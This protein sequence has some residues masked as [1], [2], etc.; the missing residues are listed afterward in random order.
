MTTHL[1][2]LQGF[3]LQPT[4]RILNDRPVVHIFGRLDD[5][6]TFLVRDNRQR[7][8]FW[9]RSSDERLARD[10]GASVHPSNRTSTAGDPLLRVEVRQ[11]S[12][13]PQ[14]RR[15]LAGS[16]VHCFEADVRFAMRY[17]IDRGVRSAVTITGEAR[18]GAGVDWVF[19]NP[20]VG[21]GTCRPQL[22]VLSIDIET[23][24]YIDR[25]LSIAFCG[26]GVSEAML[27]KTLGAN[28]PSGSRGFDSE[29]EMLN[30]FAQRVREIDPD[31]ITGWNVIGFD[32]AFLD[33]KSQSLRI[34]LDLGRMPG[35]MGLRSNLPNDKNANP[36]QAS[37]SGRVVLDG[38]RLLRGSFVRMES[39]ALDNVA[40]QV[41]GEGK[42]FHGSD[43][44]KEILRSFY[45]DRDT[46]VRYNIKDAQLVLDILDKLDLLSLTIERSLLTGM[47][48]DRVAAS[49]A[50]FDYLYL[51]ELH[52]EGLVAPTV[53]DSEVEGESFGGTVLQPEPGLY[54]NVLV[55][56]FKSLYPS[57]IRTFDID[58]MGYL[59]TAL[60]VDNTE[61]V[62]APN[63]AA[64]RR[65]SSILGRLLSE[66]FKA[67]ESAKQRQDSIAS[68]A[69]KILMNSFYGVLGTSASRFYNPRLAGA[70][71]SFAREFLLWSR[72]SMQSKGFNVLYGDTDSLF[73]EAGVDDPE[74][75]RAIGHRLA[76]ELN[77]E[78]DKHI[79]EQ[80]QVESR[81]ELEFEQLYLQLLFPRT[82]HGEGGAM[83]R[84]VGQ[85]ENG[86]ILFTGME[87]VRRDW[88]E[89]ARRL[90][91]RLYEKF[92]S[93][94][95]VESEIHAT[96][97]DLRAGR[98]DSLL[99]Y[100]KALRKKLD[101]YTATTPPHVA[102]ARKLKGKVPRLIDYVITVAGPEPTSA[103]ESELDYQHYVEK[104]LQPIAEPILDL[105]DLR[106]ERVIGDDKQME[107]F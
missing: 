25:L 86:E 33:A 50:S 55:F 11:P 70:I 53:G 28:E 31:I 78:L 77:Q 30:A 13:A 82:R 42:V 51:S 66:L 2:P 65:G 14:L 1:E 72:A 21:P 96:V 106:F 81:L 29:T 43:R 103:I 36:D 49:I 24:P 15:R 41:L 100:R 101:E 98:H 59:G 52:R 90:Q 34:P 10:L 80:W 74:A 95:P 85:A 62:V 22:S 99:V 105:L 67:R 102:A 75:A 92:F 35:R 64:F 3:V 104:Q 71:T 39:Y 4:Y 107:L 94:Q 47:P 54:R 57:I 58:P 97:A 32:L 84:Y 61:A 8:S 38:I 93:G 9:I 87:V 60:E 7:P 17:L 27:L 44:V 63:G 45:E 5:G 76:I 23:D 20:E 56:D 91:K 48:L 73:V 12:D 68:Q 89:L 16:G 37:I 83:K 19:D 40:Q 88:T 26:C 69:I 6:N 46:F 79:S 18:P